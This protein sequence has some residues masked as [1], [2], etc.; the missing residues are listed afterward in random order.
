MTVYKP[1]TPALR[2]KINK[3]YNEQINEL[4][5]CEDNG[6][7]QMLKSLYGIQRN[8]INSLPDGYLIP[9]KD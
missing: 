7:V 4:S 1:M 3:A 9:F 8:L 5:E 6:Y 2:R